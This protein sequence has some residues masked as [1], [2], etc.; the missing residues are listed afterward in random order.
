MLLVGFTLFAACLTLHIVIGASAALDLTFVPSSSSSTRIAPAL[1]VVAL[2]GASLLTPGGPVPSVLD[3]AAILLIHWALASAYA[4]DG[5]YPAAQARSPSLEIAYAVG[6]SMP[7]GLSREESDPSELRNAR[8]L[9]GGRSGREPSHSGRRRP[10][11]RP[12][13][14]PG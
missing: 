4:C 13:C 9:E 2:L 11:R 7:R 6:Q 10:L 12:R 5:C 1:V 3:A 14:P 8:A